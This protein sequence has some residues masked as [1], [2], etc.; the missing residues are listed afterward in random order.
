MNVDAYTKGLLTVIA[1]CLVW[2]CL[3]GVMPAAN[4]QAKLPPPTPVVLV[5]AN[6]MPIFT[7]QGLRVNFGNT[8]VPVSVANNPVPVEVTNRALPVALRTIQRT[9]AWDPIEVRVLREPP[10]Q[11]PIP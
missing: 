6:G 10:T 1:A 9:A 2:M 7:A 5:D 4:A 11:R 8:I 3:N